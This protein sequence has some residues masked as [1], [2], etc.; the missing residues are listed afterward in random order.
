YIK[1][2]LLDTG[3]DQIRLANIYAPTMSQPLENLEEVK[4]KNT[5]Y[6]YN[7]KIFN[8]NNDLVESSPSRIFSLNLKLCAPLLSMTEETIAQNERI[9]V[10]GKPAEKIEKTSR[11]ELTEGEK[12]VLKKYPELFQGNIELFNR[13]NKYWDALNLLK[14]ADELYEKELYG[15]SIAYYTRT[16]NI[17][18]D[19][20]SVHYK[21][22][23][24]RFKAKNYTGAESDFKNVVKNSD[25]DNLVNNGMEQLKLLREKT[26]SK[27]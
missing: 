16:L 22:G 25:D 14:V 21:R 15:E 23:L 24:A 26:F 3:I 9:P 2:K 8:T 11:E 20:Y 12:N 18:P 1:E 17:V 4:N 6:N 7:K 19:S 27:F 13:E 5:D 10:D